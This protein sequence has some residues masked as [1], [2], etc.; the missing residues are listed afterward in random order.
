MHFPK[1]SLEEFLKGFSEKPWKVF[2]LKILKNSL[3]NFLKESMEKFLKNNLVTMNLNIAIVF[4][5]GGRDLGV[6]RWIFMDLE[7]ISR[8]LKLIKQYLVGTLRGLQG[9]YRKFQG[10]S[11]AL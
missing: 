7:E 8:K 10:V 11:G 9:G 5:G 2:L 1:K 6:S 4:T 3:E